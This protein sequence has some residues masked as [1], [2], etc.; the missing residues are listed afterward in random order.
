[1]SVAFQIA[2]DV[3]DA[4]AA[5]ESDRGFGKAIGNDVREGKKTLMAIHAAENASPAAA[6]RLEEI[7]WAEE[8][9]AAEI[10][11][12]I[13]ILD[14]TDSIEYARERA[15]DLSASARERLD[16]LD[17]EPDPADDLAAFTRFVVSRNV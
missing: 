16:G 11:E 1:M 14:E 8:N 12:A 6:A 15:L 13:G 4:E 2:D 3:L 5:I 7:L 9:S 17:L 10:G